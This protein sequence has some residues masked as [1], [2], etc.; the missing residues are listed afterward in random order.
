M[1]TI[2]VNNI[3]PPNVGEGVSIDGLQMPTAGPL[4]N[5]NLITNG[6]MQVAQ[7][8]TSLA[9]TVDGAYLVDRFKLYDAATNTHTLTQSQ[10]SNVPYFV[11]GESGFSKSLRVEV[12]S[13]AAT[14]ST[15][16]TAISH[17]IEGF[18]AAQLQYGTAY[19]KTVTLSFFC[20]GNVSAN[21]SVVLRNGAVNY[22]YIAQFA[23]MGI[24]QWQHR[25][26][27]IPG[28][29][30][31]TWLTDNGKGLE[32]MWTLDSGNSYWGTED[33]WNTSNVFNLGANDNDFSDTTGNYFEITG[34]QL[35]VGSKTTPFEHKSYAETLAKCQRY[36]Q[37]LIYGGAG[38]AQEFLYSMQISS[39]SRAVTEYFPT[40]LRT[41]PTM[42]VTMVG[43][44]INAS[45]A[46]TK[47]FYISHAGTSG[48]YLSAFAADAEL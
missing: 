35:E 39:A 45:L 17:P 34:V 46:S 28:A 32:V 5:R 40:E 20:R 14:P 22:N 4:S 9:N 33:A 31:G 11:N 24:E 30:A 42:T 10:S 18:D 23:D 36:Y 41:A 15:G 16:Y 29:A 21:Y 1:S 19:A 25:K 2:K 43:G 8:G 38:G 12:T 3:V 48:A 37:N 26:I 6:A 13:G 47:T 44:T 7:R 27:T